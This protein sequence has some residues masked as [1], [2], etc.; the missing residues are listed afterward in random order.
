MRRFIL[1]IIVLSV[2]RASYAEYSL[3]RQYPVAVDNGINA[4]FGQF[5][6]RTGTYKAHDGIDYRAGVGTFVYPVSTGTARI[7]LAN[8]SAWGRYVIVEHTGGFKTRYAHLNEIYVTDGQVITTTT[9][10]L[11]ASGSTEGG[12]IPGMGPH[13]H[14][15][16]G[17]PDVLPANTKNPIVE[18]LKQPSYGELKIIEDPMDWRKIKLLGTGTDETFDGENE[19]LQAVR[20]GK[21]TLAVI[22]AY[23]RDNKYFNPYKIEFEV[24]NTSNSSWP[25]QTKVIEFDTMQ[26]ILAS[27]ESYYCFSKPY[28][29]Y[30]SSEA[31][32]ADYYFIKFY[33]TA[34]VY[35]ITAKIYSCYRDGPGASG[36]HLTTPSIADGTLIE[37]Y[38]TVGMNTVD[39]IDN[40][41]S[42]AWLPDDLANRGVM[43][44]SVP[45]LARTAGVSASTVTPLAIPEVFYAFANNNVITSNLLDVD[46][47]LQQKALIESRSTPEANW[48][49]EI[50]NESGTAV[51]DRIAVAKQGW[52]RTEWGAGKPAGTYTFTVTATNAAG[53]TIFK[54]NDK[55]T[56]DNT[57]PSALVYTVS[58]SVAAAEQIISTKIRPYENL[59]SMLVNVVKDGDYSM[60]EERIYSTPFAEKDKEEQVDWE[61]AIAYPEGFYRL[62]YVMTDVAGNIAK[63]YSPVVSVNT[64]GSY[65]PPS[66]TIEVS[67]P[68]LPEL[69]KWEDRPKVSDIAFDSSGNQYVLFGRYDKLVKYSP[70]GEVLGKIEGLRNPLGLAVS[71]TGDRVL[72]ADTYAN[73]ALIYDGDLNLVK[74][75]KG[76]D[77]YVTYGE[78]DS[79]AWSW[80]G[81][82]SYSD[83][84]GA[85]KKKNA[86]E[87]YF[88]PEDVG[89][90]NNNIYV[91]D[92]GKHRLLKYD[93]SG[94]A[95]IFSMLKADLKEEARA[96]FNQNFT[97]NGQTVDKALFYS[98]ALNDNIV[99]DKG[100]CGHNVLQA[101]WERSW[102]REMYYHY[103]PAGDAAGQFIS[104][105]STAADPSGSLYVADT[106]NNRIQKFNP[107]GSFAAKFGEG[108]LNNPKGIDIDAYGN[109]WVADTG[110]HRIVQFD[111]VGTLIKEYKS[112]E[113]EINPQKIKVKDGKI[114][115]A[116]ANHDQPLVWNIGGSL[117]NVKVTD[118]WISPNNDSVKDAT[119]IQYSLS[120]PAE[121]SAQ[122]IPKTSGGAVAQSS[123][124]LLAFDDL[125]RGMGFNE[126]TWGGGLAANNSLLANSAS[127]SGE[128]QAIADGNY[129]LKL[130]AS[131]GDYRKSSSVDLNIDTTPPTISLDRAP[132]A[133]SPNG[134]HV[135]DAMQINYSISD[136]L[137]PTAEAKL[138]LWK[139]NH[140]VGILLAENKTLEM[141]TGTSPVPTYECDGQLPWDGKVSGYVSEGNYILKLE[142]T[143]LAGNKAVATR[144]VIVDFQPP[145]IEAVKLTNPYFSPNG[146]GRKDNTEI[147]FYLSDNYATTMPATILIENSQGGEVARIANRIDLVPGEYCFTWEGVSLPDG[148]Y[149]ARIYAEDEAGNLGTMEPQAVAID[150]VPPT[151]E[152]FAADPNP[153]TPNDDGVKDRTIFSYKLS[154][155]CNT[156]LKIFREDQSKLFRDYRQN[157]ITSGSFKWDGTGFH[158]EILGEDHPF[159]LYAEDRAG[160]ATTTEAQIIVVDHAPSLV[161]YAFAEP[162]PFSPVNPK[163]NTTTIRYFL[164]RDGL[165]VNAAITG[166]EGR[167]VK[168][169]VK[170]EV[171]NKGE[172]TVNWDGGFD[173]AYDGPRAS[174]NNSRVADGAWEVKVT[175]TASDEPKPCLT[176]N[177]VL[178]DNVQPFIMADPVAIDLLNQKASLTYSIPETSSVEVAVYDSHD[179]LIRAVNTATK[180]AGT[181]TATWQATMADKE[182]AYFRVTAIDRAL[183]EAEKK[184]ELFAIVPQETL[185]VT[186]LNVVPA[187]FT[188]NGDGLLDQTR[189]A[190]HLSGGA[191]EY[192]VNIAVQ[193]ETGSTVKT[194]VRNDPQNAGTYSFYWDGKSDAGLVAP[195]G[196]YRC[197]IEAADKLGAF[198]SGA[199]PVLLVATKPTVGLAA[200][201]PIFSPNG[202]G[203]KDTVDFN[204]SINYATLYISGEALVKLE[205]LNAS[206]EA[207]WSRVFNKTA[208]SYI[209]QYDGTKDDG[210]PLLA[211]EYYVRI[212]GQ[213]ALNGLAVQKTNPLT[214]DYSSPE[215]SD[216]TIS[217]TYAKL[218]D[219]IT[220]ALSF[221]ELLAEDPTVSVAMSDG[222]KKTPLL[223]TKEANN[224]TYS[225]TIAGED[226]EGLT[227][228]SVEAR[229][230]AFNPIRKSKSLMIDKTNPAVTN[231]SVTPTPAST[232]EVSGQVS[233]KFNVS[234]PLKGAPKVYVTQNGTVPQLLPVNGSYEAKY[235]VITGYDGPALITVEVVDLADNESRL[236]NHDSLL[237]DTIAP[238]FSSLECEIVGNPEYNKQ[239]KEGTTATLRFKTSEPL[240]FNPEVRV[241]G[242]PAVYDGLSANE[243][244]YKY[245]VTNADMN[246]TAEVTVSG[247]DF[248]LNAGSIT[249]T[250]PESF[251]IDLIRPLVAIASPESEMI[252]TPSPF[253]TNGKPGIDN[254]QTRLNYEINEPGYVTISVHKVTNS[255]ESYVRTDFTTDNQVAKFTKGWES[256][257]A[258]FEYWDGRIGYNQTEYDGNSNGFADPG[259]FAFIVD[260]R[261]RA[262]NL[263]EGK[264]GGTCWVQDNVLDLAKA[265]R[266]EDNPFPLYFSPNGDGTME[267]TTAYFRVSLGITPAECRRPERISAFGVQ[268]IAWNTVEVK[269]IG[270]YT[271]EVYNADK[272]QLIKVIRANEV[273]QSNKVIPVVWDGRNSAGNYVPEG[274]YRI[275]ID[276]RDYLGG[277]ALN[278]LLTLTAT[279]D[280]TVPVIVS[281]EPQT[282]ALTSWHNGKNSIGNPITYTY[283]VDYFDNGN[284]FASK[285]ARAEYRI[286]SNGSWQTIFNDLN[287]G[288]YTNNWGQA[289][290]GQCTEGVNIIYVRAMDKAGNETAATFAFYARKDET[291]PANPSVGIN[292]SAAYTAS[293]SVNLQLGAQDPLSGVSE[294]WVANDG[295]GFQSFSANPWLLRDADGYRTVTAKFKDAAGNWSGT[296][297]DDINLDRAAPSV[298]SLAVDRNPMSPLVSPALTFSY[299]LNETATVTLYLDGSASSDPA[300][301]I[302]GSQSISYNVNSS[303]SEGSH[304]Y[305]IHAVDLAGNSADSSANSFTVDKMPPTIA[306]ITFSRKVLFP[307]GTAASTL[308]SYQASDPLSGV[309]DVDAAI[310]N[311]SGSVVRN[312][313]NV[314]GE[315]T[316]DAKNN[317]GV[318]VP[319]GYYTLE[320]TATD[321]AG[322][323]STIPGSSR[324]RVKS[325]DEVVMVDD[326][327]SRDEDIRISKIAK[328]S[329]TY[330][331]NYWTASDQLYGYSAAGDF[332]GDGQPLFA[333]LNG[334]NVVKIFNP[335]N[336]T[337]VSSFSIPN[338]SR[339]AAG[340]YDGNGTDEIAALGS[341][342]W[343]RI[344]NYSGLLIKS[345]KAAGNEMAAGDFYGDGYDEI[346]TI[347]NGGKSVYLFDP[348]SI[349]DGASGNNY[350]ISWSAPENLG[351]VACGD[352]TGDG[353]EEIAL[354]A[355]V[356][357]SSAY[358]YQNNY[359]IY[360][361]S[362][363]LKNSLNFWDASAFKYVTVGDY[364]GDGLSEVAAL[365]NG[366]DSWMA[367]FNPMASSWSS[368]LLKSQGVGG[369]YCSYPASEDILCSYDYTSA[370]AVVSAPLALSATLEL[371]I[372]TAP[373]KDKQN[374]SSIRP[375]FAWQHHKGDTAEYKIDVAKNDTFTIANQS[376][377]KS[378][379]TGSPDSA[380]PALFNYTYSIHE[381]DPGLDKDTY[382]WKVTALT[383]NEAATSEVWSFTIQPDLTL[384]GIT[385]YPNP[386][387]P[388]REKTKIRYKLG[389]DADEVK[390]RIYDITGSLVTEL[391]GTTRGEMSSVWDKYNDVDWNG[392]NGRGD[393]VVNG[394]YPFEVVARLGDRSVSGRGKIAVL[395]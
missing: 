276:A 356:W 240:K 306:N 3:E 253:Q 13:L 24:E 345:F 36:F 346:V 210:S 222:A 115:I 263:I 68:A 321:G 362:G 39:F 365:T 54:S 108:V 300:S 111:P 319:V 256:A 179:A 384:T 79:Y 150:T 393:K 171:Q 57:K 231:V 51:V 195:D 304:S 273:L 212:S 349:S 283:D 376:F 64:S 69:P 135:N 344:Y 282:Q 131:F 125:S 154:E 363:T 144:E 76:Q 182:L 280:T 343:I 170:D 373:E 387:S 198:I 87:S 86:R 78:V 90:F 381:F 55:I 196:R 143:D 371:P 323:V 352:M 377:A 155:P 262:G 366:S 104:P 77:V 71:P 226:A 322:N 265:E 368:A 292:S 218:G 129:S 138:T 246:G 331:T 219:E 149:L 305:Y 359:Y 232:P 332:L 190:Y 214:V 40:R 10:T 288:S 163:N 221:P 63:A 277:Q 20:P 17:S 22:E 30:C 303:I 147:S 208:G 175:A 325:R 320:F 293:R 205:V 308:V 167:I 275:V 338:V 335:R 391:D 157:D 185:Q 223:A 278:N 258:H 201:L 197:V 120:Q 296:V 128:P 342:S 301:Q 117:A 52:L 32:Y 245:D 360:G 315:F 350:Y 339:L 53:A 215:P 118:V 177:T 348:G 187:T 357:F 239:A 72:V 380:D 11:G 375:T 47:N 312:I 310:K 351:Y 181:H 250:S 176:S 173:P 271:A 309:A 18:G 166:K 42:Y 59:R 140:L 7:H 311:Q 329:W 153:F 49:V 122:L 230:L 314:G 200:S 151:V 257:G 93:L 178:V 96:A 145:R 244:T 41:Y 169:L 238:A 260:V 67:A 12:L 369:D 103:N 133:V 106:G 249:S 347:T 192:Q 225:Y 199:A 374:V 15:G 259:K 287:A 241:N 75:I 61:D 341:D 270:T 340:D 102:L 136:N 168:Q 227:T 65:I 284:S 298:T 112:E 137:S 191:P 19:P 56:I 119:R 91:I 358:Q 88:L 294:T 35:K 279:V 44:A 9:T 228:V 165:T 289:V 100:S 194:I 383:T 220:V 159:N 267:T 334:S 99:F 45:T 29:T 237:V 326:N 110:N 291:A 46:P 97:F 126:E 233:I 307:D 361:G 80:L 16:L 255:Q 127:G 25:K 290:Y 83:S 390:I 66:A 378:P 73:R 264:W 21:A 94:E 172:H 142:A 336:Q 162:D 297:T 38:V 28:V 330:L 355:P 274:T 121:I 58:N 107:D 37:R 353:K 160:N 98:N 333:T 161:P 229:D 216:F 105:E 116:D 313:N 386:F 299:S 158:G 74:E 84:A 180:P 62:Q 337:V 382:Y 48:L 251:V 388:N 247:Y 364:A 394:I 8:D 124:N 204:Y 207:V 316:W 248:A 189:F 234:E 139:N 2:C 109:V 266:G 372:L 236:T 328:G 295:E 130:I 148:D 50:K 243:Y 392:T 324:I 252:A 92:N 184:S 4:N 281:H 206:S 193:T 123:N 152:S 174:G 101:D 272:S 188:P 203:E 367:I 202:D 318:F 327:G 26:H 14:F 317:G 395:K 186:G 285:L 213:D 114:Y 33:P 379:N 209:Y 1:I 302:S 23:Q 113:Y 268:D 27:F 235:N 85:G 34:G 134:D 81:N 389:A 43:L 156:E 132:P 5:R 60:V 70:A 211:G 183:N 370:Y 217:H 31:S 385:N 269:A 254:L 89:L 141:R 261:D 224:Y 286:G 354:S 6:S 95:T 82:T 164:T 146:D 242:N